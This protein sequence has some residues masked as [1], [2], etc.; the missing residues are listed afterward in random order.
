MKKLTLSL[1]AAVISGCFTVNAVANVCPFT[2]HF[3]IN[4]T[5]PVYVISATTT[6]NLAYDQIS[7]N[8]FRL[9]CADARQTSGGDLF[10]EIG[11]NN[12]VK[13]S[14]TL[15]DGPFVMNPSI[16][17]IYCGGA[18]GKL[19]FMGMEHP[20]GSYNYTLNFA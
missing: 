7:A 3:V 6:G 12:N 1:F 5:I 17:D 11:V 16:A 13:C 9:S 10:I 18:D 14:L 15:H 8:Y 20:F 2:D 4:S 19:H